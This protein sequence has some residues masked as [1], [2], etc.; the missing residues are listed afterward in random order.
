MNSKRTQL[1]DCDATCI[2][3]EYKDDTQCGWRLH[4]DKSWAKK[5]GRKCPIDN[6]SLR[7]TEV[8]K[9]ASKGSLF[10]EQW[11]GILMLNVSLSA[12]DT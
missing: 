12:P 4:L 2:L 7:V 6:R 11:L 10:L 9:K 5:Q 1:A 3:L 8:L